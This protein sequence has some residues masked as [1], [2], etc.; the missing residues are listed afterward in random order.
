MSTPEPDC[1]ALIIGAGF[2]G[3][4][5]LHRLREAGFRA[6]LIDA[7]AE[8]GG[9]WYW[10]CYPGARVDSH[11]PIYEFSLP[12]LWQDWTWSERF[13]GGGELR[14]YFRYVCDKLEL[15][16]DMA[17]GTRVSG[18]RFDGDNNVWRVDTPQGEQ[19]SARFLL[20]CAG[21]AAKSYTP[22]IVGLESFAGERHHTAHWPQGGLSF[23]GKR[24]A[25]IGTGASG[26]Q[27]AQEAARDAAQLTLFQRTPIL[28]LPMQQ[29]PLSLEQ[30]A[31]EKAAYRAIFAKRQ[32]S[33]GGFDADRMEIS[34]L[35][36]DAV[37]RTATFERLWRAGGL[38]F[39][40]NNFS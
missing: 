21:F 26:V 35:D 31:Q 36:V 6:K 10:N 22:D 2:S 23:A 7:A 17:M 19:I 9:I 34:A 29:Q 32:T 4:Y 18:A 15:W 33:N 28:A 27:V 24:V 8:P 5:L 13:P 12:E 16:A 14:R 40:Y 3:I 25:I 38:R 1:D 37:E 20:P 11:V 39:W 30:Q